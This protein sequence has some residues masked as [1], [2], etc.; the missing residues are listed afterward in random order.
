MQMFRQQLKSLEAALSSYKAAHKQ[1]L[2]FIQK[3][4]AMI[5]NAKET[6]KT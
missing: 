2:Q 3:Y 4:K 1:R 5:H 6:V